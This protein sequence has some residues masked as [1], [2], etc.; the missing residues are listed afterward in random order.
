MG[1]FLF[2]H[3]IYSYETYNQKGIKGR[4]KRQGN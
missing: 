1:D 3:Y 4:S 2:N